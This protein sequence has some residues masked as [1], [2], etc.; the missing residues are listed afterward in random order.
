MFLFLSRDM[1]VTWMVVLPSPQSFAVDSIAING[2]AEINEVQRLASKIAVVS[3]S[4]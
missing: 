2:V 3:C 1:P 4:N